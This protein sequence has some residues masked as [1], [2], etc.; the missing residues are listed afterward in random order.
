MAETR[1]E[2]EGGWEIVLSGAGGGGGGK[3]GGDGPTE[4]PESLRS[5]SEATIV[6]L[7]SEGEVYG[8]R[9][10]VDPLTKIFLDGTPIKN[11]DGSFNYGVAT[12]FTGSA[13]TANGKGNL[14]P[15]ISQS[16]PGLQRGTITGQVNSVVVDY[17]VGT[18]NQDPMPG[19]DD[20]KA[21]QS[22]GLRLA[23]VSGPISRTTLSSNF[24]RLRVR[25]G[26][27]G[28]FFIDKETGDVKGKTIT[29]NVKIRPVGGSNFTNENVSITGKSRGAV[30]FEYEY[31]LTGT[32]PWVVTLERLTEDPTSTSVSDDL[33][34]K[35]IVGIIDRSFR[36]P[37]S[38][39]LGLK[40][41]AE[42]FTGV[43]SIGIEMLGVMVKIPSNYNPF[44]RQYSGVWD[45]TFQT[46]WTN[47]PAWIFYDLLTNTRYGAGEFISE[48]QVDRY[49][50]LPIAQY[51]D[52][53]VPDGKGGLEPRMTFNAYITDRGEAYEVLNALAAAFM[54]LTYFAEGTIVAIQDRPKNV[55]KVFSPANVIQEVDDDGVVTEPPFV[56]EGSARKARKTVALISWNDPAD[57]YKEKIE[58][59]ED[60]A[61]IA[62]YGIQELEIRAIGTTSQGQAQRIGRRA[63]LT[64]QLETSTVSFKVFTEGNF[65]LPGEIIG[66]ADPA[67]QGKRFSGRI[68]NATASEVTIDSPFTILAGKS[69]SLTITLESGA[70]QSC[71]VTNAAGEASVL[72]ISPPLPSLPITGGMWALQEDGEG[73]ETYRVG[74]V[75]EDDGK[76]TIFATEYNPAKFAE[77]DESTML[78]LARASVAGPQIVPGVNSGSIVLEVNQ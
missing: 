17:R 41:G 10:G 59:V 34:F 31:K 4:D 12:F 22:V 76:L 67:R 78:G 35:G 5:R 21:E 42:N 38:C 77:T 9:P 63:L 32:G 74:A 73:Y 37:N 46:N 27:G 18:Q 19:F 23:R 55:S 6:A 7:M 40:I 48:S 24:N 8:F 53:L 3:K 68:V 61:G 66:I 36:F 16:I 60:A 75:N 70:V 69:Y 29:F 1:Y 54:G 30:D 11:I 65:I 72:A 26:I 62:R 2:R 47:N 64:N 39:L 25:V 28:L 56:Y 13:T 14:I 33:F 57:S 51:C 44:T 15:A 50:L 45:G 49:S 20:V 52:E 58:Y 43:P 71:T